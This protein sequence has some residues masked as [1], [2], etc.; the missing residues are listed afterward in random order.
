MGHTWIF[1]CDKWL[2]KSQ[3]DCLLELEL[4]PKAQATQAYTPRKN[5]EIQ[6]KRKN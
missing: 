3:G 2:S 1:P 4:Y 5:E 6:M